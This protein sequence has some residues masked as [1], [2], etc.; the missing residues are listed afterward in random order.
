[1]ATVVVGSILCSAPIAES[2]SMKNVLL[3][4][5]ITLAAVLCVGVQAGPQSQTGS[6][7]EEQAIRAVLARFFEGWN[8]H[9][10]DK[11]VS[12]YAEDIDHIDVFGEWH[13][14]R[15]AIRDEL[16]RLHA[17]PLSHSE[18]QYTVEKIRFLKP[19]IAVIQVSM[20][21]TG[22]PNLATYVM[23]KQTGGWLTVSFANVAPHDPPWKK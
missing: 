6:P 15:E 7:D 16:A 4:V 13:K 3:K 11:M 1:M 19:D 10:A 22:G 5:T 18:K 20:R 17:G 2:V 14:G 23:Q 12:A 9:D 21:G 8:A